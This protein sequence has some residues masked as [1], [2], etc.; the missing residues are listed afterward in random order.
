MSVDSV[1][2]QDAPAVLSDLQSL[3][4]TQ[5]LAYAA[6]PCPP[7]EQRQQWLKS[8]RRLLSDERE[9]LIDTISQTAQQQAA[10]L[11]QASSAVQQVDALTQENAA[12]VE[13]S[14]HAA[15]ALAQQAQRLSHLV[16]GFST[17]S[18]SSANSPRA[19]H[20]ALSHM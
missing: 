5:R 14:S 20:A 11:Q 9:V 19:E 10:Q 3:L 4:D 17:D 16:A 1:H 12:L 2:R 7:L 6:H 8:L 15:Q 18:P 13:Q